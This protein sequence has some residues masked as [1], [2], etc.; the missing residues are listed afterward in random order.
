VQTARSQ[1]VLVG[2]T[3]TERDRAWYDM[4]RAAMADFDRQM[5]T[6]IRNNF[7]NFVVR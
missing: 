4:T 5:E 3:P 7:G 2:I 6:E 1:S